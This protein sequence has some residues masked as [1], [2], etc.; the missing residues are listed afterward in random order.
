MC[1]DFIKGNTLLVSE[2]MEKKP[3]LSPDTP[4]NASMTTREEEMDGKMDKIA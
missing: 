3:G 4:S 1:K 2:K